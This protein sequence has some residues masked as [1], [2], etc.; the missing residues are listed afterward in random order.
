[1]KMKYVHGMNFDYQVYYLI[2]QLQDRVGELEASY[3]FELFL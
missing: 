2:N 1:M 3:Y